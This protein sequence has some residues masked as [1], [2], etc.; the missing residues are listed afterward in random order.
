MPSTCCS[1]PHCSNRG[2]HLF[3]KNEK[4]K[5]KWIEAIKRKKDGAEYTQYNLDKDKSYSPHV[6]KDM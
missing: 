5:K 6:V 3:P 2:G 4:L 1:V